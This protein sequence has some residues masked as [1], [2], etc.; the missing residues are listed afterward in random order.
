M[1][2]ALL[3]IALA[4]FAK[5]YSLGSD[6]VDG[7]SSIALTPDGGFVLR[8]AKYWSSSSQ[9]D[10]AI[11]FMDSL[12]NLVRARS[13]GWDA[14]HEYFYGITAVS[15][16]YVLA[17]YTQSISGGYDIL[18]LKVD[19]S[20]NVL[21]YRVLGTTSTDIAHYVLATSDGGF[22][23]TG[24]TYARGGGDALAL[25]LD[26][27]GNLQ[28]ATVW[29]GSGLDK[30][31][32]A[33]ET[34]SGY[35]VTGMYNYSSPEAFLAKLTPSGTLSWMKAYSNSNGSRGYGL[36]YDGQ[37][38][39]VTGQMGEYS[40]ADALVFKVD[41]TGGF[42]GARAYDFAGN[43]DLFYGAT[44]DGNLVAV[45]TARRSSYDMVVLKVS[46]AGT[47]VWAKA[48]DYGWDEGYSVVPVVGGYAVG[49]GAGSYNSVLLTDTNASSPCLTSLSPAI[50]SPALTPYTPSDLSST[51]M[52]LTVYSPPAI[53]DTNV[54]PSYGDLC[55]AV[56][57]SECSTPSHGVHWEVVDGGIRFRATSPT[58]IR[59]YTPSGETVFSG[60]VKGETF[61]PLRRGV[62]LWKGGK[63]IVR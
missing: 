19:L 37:D 4:P 23:V 17:G 27:S 8:A 41:T 20:G 11:V 45:G 48:F 31:Y 52:A 32:G 24:Y 36:V 58:E 44:F 56:G 25:K 15:D 33:V 35:F 10:G 2:N 60:K 51:S 55:P 38:L 61:V 62:Y 22:L 3:L 43:E 30:A 59:I 29:G 54:T 50:T 28:W 57:I 47:L 12:G 34:P 26:G 49:F 42:V 40:Q 14:D 6:V 9:Y 1:V 63:A 46:P 7:P 53:N 16:G 5:G 18:V 13:Y 39:Y 21:W